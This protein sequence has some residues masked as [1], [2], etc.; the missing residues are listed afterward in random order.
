MADT[1]VE[2]CS[3][4][5]QDRRATH[6]LEVDTNDG[7]RCGQ[8]LQDWQRWFDSGK[9]IAMFGESVCYRPAVATAVASGMQPSR[10]AGYHPRTG[11][12][13]L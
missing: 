11:S 13:L 9:L 10:Y 4:S 6:H 3:G 12:I 8:F 7:I 1:N 2:I 5:S